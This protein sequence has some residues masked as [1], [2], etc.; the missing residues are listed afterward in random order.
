[1]AVMTGIKY[2]KYTRR[3]QNRDEPRNLRANSDDLCVYTACRRCPTTARRLGPPA[4]PGPWS[5][6]RVGIQRFLGYHL[7]RLK[8]NRLVSSSRRQR[9]IAELGQAGD[10][11]QCERRKPTYASKKKRRSAKLGRV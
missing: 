5:E 3:A 8:E 7:P 6:I 4:R 9:T 11:G 2:L 10:D 1:M